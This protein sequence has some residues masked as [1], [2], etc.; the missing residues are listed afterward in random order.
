MAMCLS[1]ENQEANI[2]QYDLPN[3]DYL[4][5]QIPFS[6]YRNRRDLSEKPATSLAQSRDRSLFPARRI[7]DQ[8]LILQYNRPRSVSRQ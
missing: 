8:V 2:R 1:G 7:S 4:E 6:K 3:I 5:S